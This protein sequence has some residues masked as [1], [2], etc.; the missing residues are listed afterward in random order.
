MESSKKPHGRK[1][2]NRIE[3]HFVF[4]TATI[5]QVACWLLAT[6]GPVLRSLAQGNDPFSIQAATQSA[7]VAAICLFVFPSFVAWWI[8]MRTGESGLQI[9]EWKLGLGILAVAVPVAG[10]AIFIGGN[11]P[12]ILAAYPW[13]GEW[14]T[15]SVTN[16]VAWFMIYAIYYFAFEYFYRG[17][18]FNA[19]QRESGLAMAMWIQVIMSV[20]MHFGKPNAELLA[21]IPAGFAF[22]WIAYKTKSIWYVFGLHWMIGIINDLVS[23]HYKGWLQ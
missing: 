3:L 2:E 10:V 21:A 13:C 6:P 15:H 19:L 18:L 1:T 23:M 5:A 16:K 20:M 17:F 9:G 22:G 7:I 12:E 8:G 14:I 11:D 4:A